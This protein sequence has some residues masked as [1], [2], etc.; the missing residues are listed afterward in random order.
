MVKK[1]KHGF[2]LKNCLFGSVKLF[3]ND[4]PDKYKYSGCNIGFDSCTEFLFADGSMEKTI[5]ILEAVHIDNKIKDKL[6]LGKGPTQGSDD[7][8]LTAEAIYPINSIS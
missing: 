8:T 1:F 3:K 7:V 6:I 2:T 5:I 4:V